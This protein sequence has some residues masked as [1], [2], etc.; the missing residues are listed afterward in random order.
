ML[1]TDWVG[2]ATSLL[3]AASVLLGSMYFTTGSF[4]FS[5]YSL[6]SRRRSPGLTGVRNTIRLDAPA[7]AACAAPWRLL[8]C[9]GSAKN[10][11]VLGERTL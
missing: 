11:Y 4:F 1:V 3:S 8:T 7:A 2:S 6:P 10:P 5:L 9:S